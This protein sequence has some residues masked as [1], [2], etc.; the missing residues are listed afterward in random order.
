MCVVCLFVV[1]EAYTYIENTP[2]KAVKVELIKTLKE[3]CAG[4]MYVEAEDARLHL[5]L[6]L[7]Y[8]EEGDLSAACDMIQDVHVET[9]GALS[10]Q[11]KAEYILQQIRLNLLRKD[12]IR[13]LIQSRKMNRKIIEEE[14]FEAIKVDFYSMMVEYHRHEKDAWEI[15]QCYYKVLLICRSY[16]C[17]S[18]VQLCVS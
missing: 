2:S 16:H 13:A 18:K 11:E 15:C 14:G 5:M 6:A 1:T 17:K 4:K 3:V 7:I 9:Y 12:F 8:E 10:K